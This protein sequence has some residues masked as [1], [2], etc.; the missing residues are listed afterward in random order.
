[1]THNS[2][3][4][5]TTLSRIVSSGRCLAGSTARV[6]AAGWNQGQGHGQEGD[7]Y[8]CAV[9]MTFLVLFVYIY[10]VQDDQW[11]MS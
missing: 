3:S 7:S 9:I 8:T 4:G 6:P 11:L 5:E 1:M 2:N 10:A